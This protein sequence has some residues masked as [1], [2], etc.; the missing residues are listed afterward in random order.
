MANEPILILAALL[1]VYAVLGILYES[2]IH[3]MT[4]LSTLPSAGVGAVL[5]LMRPKHFVPAHA[6]EALPTRSSPA[7][8]ASWR[9][10]RARHCFCKQFR[11]FVASRHPSFWNGLQQCSSPQANWISLPSGGLPEDTL[12]HFRFRHSIAAGGRE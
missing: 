10:C 12:G 6:A 11:T 8:V 3:P 2:Y 9:R 4:I 7:C 1:A 5:A